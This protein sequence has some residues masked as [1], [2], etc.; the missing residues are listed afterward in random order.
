VKRKHMKYLKKVLVAI[1]AT[2]LIAAP[3]A[4]LASNNIAAQ[5][6]QTQLSMSELI[7]L[8]LMQNGGVFNRNAASM[9]LQTLGVPVTPQNVNTL[10]LTVSVGTAGNTAGEP[11]IDFFNNFA[12][13]STGTRIQPASENNF[14]N[15]IG[16]NVGLNIRVVDIAMLG[17]HNSFSN[18]IGSNSPVDPNDA[19]YGN[20]LISLAPGFV[21]RLSRTQYG[22]AMSLL[23]NG[24][25]YLDVRV[26]NVH[27]NWFTENTLISESLSSYIWE[28][29]S[30]LQQNQGELI[31]LD[32][33][34]I[35]LGNASY[36]DFLEY[37]A[38]IEV[39]EQNLF[40]FVHINPYTSPLGT[41]TL[42]AATNDGYSSGVII[43]ANQPT[44]QYSFHFYRN[45]NIRS[46][47]LQQTN[48]HNLLGEIETEQTII[49][50]GDFQNRLRV[51][52]ATVTL[53]TVGANL[54]RS[55]NSWSYMFLAE[56]F[57]SF[58]LTHDV[59]SW[60]ST[61]PIIMV[62]FAESSFRDFNEQAIERI[63]AFNRNLY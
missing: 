10:M 44:S 9:L 20:P 40:D 8:I 23:N 35:S 6:E 45:E 16:D 61:T 28:V 57:N 1:I 32:F 7:G 30:F 19:M 11:V 21:S 37:I 31:I 53:E 47:W 18:N 29:I 22:N 12:Y 13:E 17:A 3:V 52:Q 24:V 54:L 36:E 27:G 33:Q 50:N 59:E 63:N 26:T 5:T 34:H 62:G 60:L 41:V 43:L 48:I 55:I 46:R 51:S 42:G 4:T 25:R 49:N 14:S 56:R 39:Y 38:S 58:L 2:N 15:I